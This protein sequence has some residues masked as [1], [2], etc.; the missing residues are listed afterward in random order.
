VA[1]LKLELRPASLD[2][3]EL[4]LAWRNDPEVR[5]ASRQ[6][7][8]VEPAEH[9]RWLSSCLADPER[10]LL[11]AELDGKPI[12]QVRFD[13]L[14]EDEREISVSLA[15]SSRGGG[16]GARLIEAGVDWLRRERG[17]TRVIAEVRGV[18][19]A[20]LLSFRQAGFR[21]AGQSA[22]EGFMRLEL[23]AGR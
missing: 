8:T 10:D 14:T 5:S 13:R 17:T 4:L 18:N 11:I 20:S 12:G 22:T 3:A 23:P 15:A 9:E 7:H 1:D 6:P 19:P 21:P 2:D 16:L